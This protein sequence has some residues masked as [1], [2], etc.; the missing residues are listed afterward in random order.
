MS[1]IPLPALNIQTQQTDP[2]GSAAKLISLRS[3]LQ[4]QQFAQQSRPIQL[5]A[6]QADLENRQLANKAE[7]QKFAQT[8]AMNDAYKSAL[9]ID[10]NTNQPTFN[11]DA[12]VQHIAAAG[13]G[14]LI[15]GLQKNFLDLDKLGGEVAKTKSDH[16]QATQDYMGELA[17][18]IKAANY[19][20]TATGALLAHAASAGGGIYANEV[21]GWK[22]QIAQDPS[23][24]PQMVDQ[25]LAGSTKQRQVSAEETA[26]AAR[27]KQAQ[28]AGGQTALTPDRI[29]QLNQLFDSRYQALHPGQT[30]PAQ[31]QLAP[32]A[33]Q[34][35]FDNVDKVMEAEEKAVG[36]KAQQDAAN[37]LHRQT[38][39]LA[40]QGRQDQEDKE[41]MKWAM[42]TGKDGN[43]VAGPVSQAKA[44]GASDAAELGATEV[45]DLMNARH[46]VNL[47][48]KVGDPKKPETQGVLQLIDSLDKDGKLGVLASR[49]NNFLA[50]GVGTSPGDDP[51]IITL[52]D[53]NMLGQTAAMLS[54]FGASGGR[55]P[56]MLKHFED[57]A[58]AKKMDAATLKAGALAM[59]DYMH[60]R[61]MM[62]TQAPAAA[63]T[64]PPARSLPT[65]GQQVTLK[66]GQTVTVKSVDEKT[67]KFT[68]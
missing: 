15:P 34:K 43:P 59:A 55:S 35:D 32:N 5:Q 68:Y 1:S 29:S 61:A 10:P 6:E 58:N 67:G 48:E 53:K 2:I 36:T 17:S 14:S 7:Q 45:K 39:V 49:W 52:I 13:Q 66:S 23:K 19:D 4:Q 44:E 21:N 47:L 37:E 22:N 12:I 57:M 25:V 38:L 51:R 20:P 31:M 54:H 40:K 63:P 8:S 24:L 27:M 56:L 3:M 28:Q 50:T 33:T 9:S 60:D 41:G 64:Q 11:R 16:V 62:P 30:A 65:V 26:A 42:W 46:T 18:S